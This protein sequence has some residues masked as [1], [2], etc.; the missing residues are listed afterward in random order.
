VWKYSYEV[1]Q[2]E[3]FPHLRHFC[4]IKLRDTVNQFNNLYCSGLQKLAC[5]IFNSPK[6]DILQITDCYGVAS[7]MG[8]VTVRTYQAERLTFAVSGLGASSVTRG[9]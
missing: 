9:G 3:T 7:L 5:K 1:F 4:V 6:T 8:V 2:K